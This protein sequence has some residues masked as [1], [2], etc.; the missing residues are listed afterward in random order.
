MRSCYLGRVYFR[1]CCL[2]QMPWACHSE[3]NLCNLTSGNSNLNWPTNF[4]ED[5]H[6]LQ[7]HQTRKAGANLRILDK[8]NK[9]NMKPKKK[10]QKT[11]H[12][13]PSFMEK[14]CKVRAKSRPIRPIP[15]LGH[16]HWHS[17][18][19]GHPWPD[20]GI[21]TAQFWSSYLADLCWSW[22]C[23][24]ANISWRKWLRPVCRKNAVDWLLRRLKRLK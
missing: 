23:P 22:S 3:E 2:L 11:F 9:Q 17:S 4:A 8:Q 6:V 21:E 7:V 19:T 16:L 15:G 18:C 24:V 14:R 1:Q 12:G 10:D 13:S 5:L 20:Q